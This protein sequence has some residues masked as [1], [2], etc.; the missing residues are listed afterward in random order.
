MPP[1]ALLAIQIVGSFAA[2]A[3]LSLTV[4]LPRLASMPRDGA[5]KLLLWPHVLRHAPLAL[6][7]PGQVDASVSSAV[8][9]TIAWGDFAS[10]V[11]ALAA[12]WALHRRGPRATR[13]VWA[14]CLV[15]TADIVVA[16]T[17]GLGGG[18]HEHALGVGWY[19]LTLYVPVVCVSQALIFWRLLAARRIA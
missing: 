2:L 6:L 19:V 10:F 1:L 16:L 9:D 13:W 17:T 3:L 7:A 8:L 18:V 14:F 11:A 12:L 5:L 4:L 15:S